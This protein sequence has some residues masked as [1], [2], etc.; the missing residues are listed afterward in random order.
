[1]LNGIVCAPSFFTFKH[2]LIISN[3]CMQLLLHVGY[4]GLYFLITPHVVV[5]YYFASMCYFSFY[6]AVIVLRVGTVSI[7]L[8]CCI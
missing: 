8:L 3:H 1:M 5:C 7:M 4:F 6:C 2:W